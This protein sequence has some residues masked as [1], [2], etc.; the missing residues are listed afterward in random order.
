MQDPTVIEGVSNSEFLRTARNSITGEKVNLYTFIKDME[1]DS[2]EYFS[3]LARY[4][5][6]KQTGRPEEQIRLVLGK[7]YDSTYTEI[8]Y[9]R[10]DREQSPF[11]GFVLRCDKNCDA[12]SFK[13]QC[14]YE[15]IKQI[16]NKVGA[17]YHNF[18]EGQAIENF[19]I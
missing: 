18:T 1:K 14:R 2:A 11:T 4:L 13:Q 6:L 7:F 17:V 19:I 3:C 16:I 10:L 9:S 12:C 8:L 15:S 5:E